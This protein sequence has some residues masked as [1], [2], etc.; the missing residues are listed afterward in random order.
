M[1][2]SNKIFKIKGLIKHYDWGGKTFIPQLLNIPN[3]D[4]KPFAE[5]WLGS[6]LD[7]QFEKVPYLMKVQDVEKMLSIQV[8]PSKEVARIKYKEENAKGI[9]LDAPHRNYKDENHKPEL[10]SPLSEFYLLHGF[11][12]PVAMDKILKE[13][14]ELNFL[15]QLFKGADYKALY[16]K[17]MTIPQE[18]VNERLRPLLERI[19][20][21]YNAGKLNKGNEDFWAARASLTFNMNGNTDRGIF[22]IYLFNVVTMH[23][24]QALFQD[25]GLPHAYLEGYTM[26]IMANSD[27]VLRGGLTPKYI[28][29]KELLEHVKYEPTV[30]DVIAG[31]SS[32]TLEEIFV[33]PATDFQLSRIKIK[34]Q[35][36][37]AIPAKK[38]DIYFVYKGNVDATADEQTEHFS[39]G[40]AFLAVPG[41]V[42]HFGSEEEAVVY[43]ASE[44]VTT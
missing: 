15:Q 25:A 1:E 10:L 44:P 12:A 27:N 43:R 9:P 18:E 7:E 31:H 41:T 17:V 36:G 40:D 30:P 34:K 42:V 37:I 8:H 13:V 4:K 19:V 28:D 23:P 11:K 2:N 32:G 22:S 5:Y 26:E 21:L 20:P 14:S 39:P 38:T 16:T 29:V 6:N 35:E 33:T 3:P 24:G